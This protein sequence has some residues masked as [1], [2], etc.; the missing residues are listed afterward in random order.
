LND[1][2]THVEEV[3]FILD[4][5]TQEGIIRAML[6]KVQAESWA[7]GFKQGYQD[8]LKDSDTQPVETDL[9]DDESW[10]E[11]PT[12]NCMKYAFRHAAH[13][14][15]LTGHFTLYQCHGESWCS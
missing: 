12:A 7:K 5:K 9:D 15:N 2:L 10:Y 14:W 6:Q 11:P 4:H 13:T 8:G 3:G 1:R